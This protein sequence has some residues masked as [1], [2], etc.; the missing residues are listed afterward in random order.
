[1]VAGAFLSPR[2][3]RLKGHQVPPPFFRSRKAVLELIPGCEQS[4]GQGVAERGLGAK[5]LSKVAQGDGCLLLSLRF[6]QEGASWQPWGRGCGRH[7]EA[8]S[9][10]TILV[11]LTFSLTDILVSHPSLV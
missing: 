4:H 3:G 7:T 10:Y 6:D 2:M 8:L 9:C 5:G 1:M 11:S